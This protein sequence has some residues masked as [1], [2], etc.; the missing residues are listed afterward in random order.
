MDV[1]LPEAT[2]KLLIDLHGVTYDEVC[3]YVL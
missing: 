1:L 3:S 2:L